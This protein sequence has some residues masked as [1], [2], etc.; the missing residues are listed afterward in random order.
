M[1][2]KRGK[3]LSEL[4]LK[5]RVFSKKNSRQLGIKR[6]GGGKLIPISLPS[7]AY[8]RQL[9][10]FVAQIKEQSA[11]LEPIHGALYLEC[12]IYD[13]KETWFQ[14]FMNG[15]S[16]NKE[17]KGVDVDNRLNSI[18]DILKESGHIVD[19]VI[20]MSA[21][22]EKYPDKRVPGTEEFGAEIK[23]FEARI[24]HGIY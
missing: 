18:F 16:L 23:I 13:H 3:L 10:L 19:D 2:I 17:P 5:G 15:E 1:E 21:Q 22:I 9:P 24:P 8:L 4:T 20:I 14:R 11:R 6:L 12:K 7:K